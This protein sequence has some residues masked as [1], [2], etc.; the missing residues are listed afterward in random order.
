LKNI[1]LII[2]IFIP[3]I[4]AGCTNQYDNEDVVAIVG[5]QEITVGDVKLF[6]NLEEKDL[7]EATKEYVKEEIMVQ[8]AKR[9]KIDV[10][11]KAA[12]LKEINNPFPFEQ[13]KEQKEYAQKTAKDLGM[14]E[15]EF[16][17]KYLE[18]STERSA[19]IM[20][21]LEKQ[22]GEID[23]G[24]SVEEYVEKVNKYA[25]SLLIKYSD[26]IDILID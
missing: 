8:D 9:M 21:L 15:E 19:Y 6:Y 25:D 13:T 16:Y 23:N 17:E 1:F 7:T 20:A 10:T 2:I 3:A 14:T 12:E 26:D 22:I 4:I 18:L 24:D 11:K 5:D